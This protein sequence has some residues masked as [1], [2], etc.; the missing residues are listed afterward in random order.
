M[1]KGR[2]GRT[3][4]RRARSQIRASLEI[5]ENWRQLELFDAGRSI[6]HSSM[7]L[8]QGWL[9]GLAPADMERGAEWCLRQA[10]WQIA[11]QPLGALSALTI[12]LSGRPV[13]QTVA[14]PASW[15]ARFAG[16]GVDVSPV[17]SRLA[18]LREQVVA[19]YA[20]LRRVAFYLLASND[21]LPRP[22]GRYAVLHYA[23]WFNVPPKCPPPHWD[24]ATWTRQARLVA[25]DTEL[26]ASHVDSETWA[27]PRRQLSHTQL[28]LPGFR[29]AAQYRAFR[30]NLVR[31]TLT[32]LGRWLTGSWW[33]PLL[34][35]EL[36]ELA[37]CRAVAKGDLADA[38]FF[39][40]QFM[41]RRPLWTWH[42]EAQGARAVLVFY[43]HNFQVVF[44]PDRPEQIIID[45]SYSLTWWPEIVYMTDTCR[46]MF[47][48]A[49]AVSHRHI[50][51]G[52]VTTVDS[53]VRIEIPRR[54]SVAIFDIAPERLGPRAAVGM[55][56]PYHEREIVRAFLE[57]ATAAV[58]EAG[59]TPV[60][61]L[62]GVL[63]PEHA[64]NPTDLRFDRHAHLEIARR[65]GAVLSHAGLP[66]HEL[67]MQT[68]AAIVLPF[69][70]PATVFRLLG[71]PAAYF[72]PTG[73]L[74]KHILMARG[75]P[76]LTSPQALQIWLSDVIGARLE[77][78]KVGT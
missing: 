3:F 19:F 69:T 39:M 44:P 4:F 17:H 16:F 14:L 61:K 10:L 12:A 70:T 45:A 60:W 53:G 35:R 77:Q 18:F 74:D 1:L 62:K 13:T 23:R 38:Y 78:R 47:D 34:F 42:A 40:P 50:T 9:K 37:H 68:D 20:G 22:R 26:W 49:G 51:A 5:T 11:K 76:I 30:L 72:D 28:S 41:H 52:A 67:A 71:R 24:W 15:R 21:R 25:P 73:K 43:S 2:P 65:Y 27:D 32:V 64:I 46:D 66:V 29:T 36:V 75:A 7:G 55:P 48:A 63:L 57:Q 59:A 33:A 8:P 56:Q 54:P 6:A 31:L 58:V